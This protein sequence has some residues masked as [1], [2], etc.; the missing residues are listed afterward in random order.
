M[1]KKRKRQIKVLV[2]GIIGILVI[3]IG[4]SYAYIKYEQSQ[5]EANVVGTECLK[6]TL[7]EE[8]EAI[9]IEKA[10]PTKEEE[11]K[12]SKPYRFTV[13]NNCNTIIDYNVNVEAMGIENRMDSKYVA[14]MLDEEEINKL[15]NYKEA[16]VY[17][18]G[19]DYEGVESHTVY[20]SFLNP[21]E[22][23]S[24]EIRMWVDE[25]ADNGSQG[26]AFLSK[27]VIEGVQNEVL[28]NGE[29]IIVR[30]EDAKGQE[31]KELGTTNGYAYASKASLVC[32][33]EKQKC[34]FKATKG[35]EVIG[36]LEG[37]CGTGERPG[38]CI[39]RK[40]GEEIKEN[41]WYQTKTNLTIQPKEKEEEEIELTSVVCVGEECSEEVK[42]RLS[43]EDKEGP[44]IEIKQI[45]SNYQGAR[46]EFEARDP[47]SGIERISCKYGETEE[48]LEKE[49]TIKEGVCELK[50]FEID[51]M[52]Y[53]AIEG[54]DKVGNERKETGMI[55][56]K[57]TVT[58][59]TLGGGSASY[60]ESRT[61]RIEREGVADTGVKNYEYYITREEEIP[62]G[63]VN[64]S[65]TTENEVT[66][67]EEGKWYVYYRT[68]SNQ[69]NRSS[70]SGY[71]EVNIYYKA[72]NVEYRNPMYPNIENV[73]Q[74]IETIKEKW[75]IS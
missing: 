61:I 16:K 2:V 22:K 5:E 35:V 28:A 66:I 54:I 58:A 26:K 18:K 64:I 33:G 14:V 49:G 15:S 46:I 53:Y 42:S 63:E 43:K 21:Y 12:K 45:E 72:S 34:Y 13:E 36:I 62:S 6:L 59:P 4:S 25:E 8:S 57:E 3:V 30:N 74:A 41:T 71:E 52:Y 70:W 17:Y 39:E 20:R 50:E 10:I 60:A 29:N 73:Q 67:T 75:G 1:E 19:E 11:G 69:G 68:V 47:K 31:I 40:E 27:V 38:E 37:S 56:S 24:H 9:K 48:K 55:S 65:G 51:K 44:E 23:R 7:K 32:E